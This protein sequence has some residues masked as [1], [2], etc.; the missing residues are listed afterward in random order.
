[1]VKNRYLAAS[2]QL[3]F[4]HL[5]P[6]GNSKHKKGRP[7]GRPNRKL[8]SSSKEVS[9]A[10]QGQAKPIYSSPSSM[11][12]LEAASS[13]ALVK[14]KPR[15]PQAAHVAEQRVKLLQVALVG[16][17][18][19]GLAEHL[20]AVGVERRGLVA[21]D[22]DGVV[23]REHH[24]QELAHVV[25]GSRQVVLDDRAMRSRAAKPSFSSSMAFT[26]MPSMRS[27]SSSV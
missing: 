11:A 12:W 21:A 2:W 23:R 27:R 17:R 24:V 20:L 1:M 26:P 3:L 5:A 19:Q 14:P 15:E 13:S 16:A 25:G 18:R 10:S 22:E 8:P 9:D 7:E 4:G 6:R